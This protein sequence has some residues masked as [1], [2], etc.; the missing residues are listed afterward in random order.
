MAKMHEQFNEYPFE[1]GNR[2]DINDPQN[3]TA[4]QLGHDVVWVNQ[5]AIDYLYDNVV[6]HVELS[7]NT[8]LSIPVRGRVHVITED[9]LPKLKARLEAMIGSGGEEEEGEEEEG[10]EEEGGE[11]EEE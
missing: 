3:Y 9:Q 2:N 11:G 4:L 6:K 8:T 5:D 1:Q 7:P 10:E